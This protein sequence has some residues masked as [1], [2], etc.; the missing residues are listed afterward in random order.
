VWID[1]V[2]KETATIGLKSLGHGGELVI[3]VDN[4]D[5]DPNDLFMRNLTV[6]NVT[7]VSNLVN[8]LGLRSPD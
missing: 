6:H 3:I 2:G 7:L 1:C 5:Y 8:I 4:A